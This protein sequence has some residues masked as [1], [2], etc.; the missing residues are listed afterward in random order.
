MRCIEEY[1][2]LEDDQLQS[3]GKARSES[4]STW[5]FPVKAPKGFKDSRAKG[6]NGGSEHNIQGASAQD[7]RSNQE[8][9]VLSMAEQDVRRPIPEA[10]KLVLYLP[11]G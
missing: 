3:K 1:K 4:S 5:W 6:T 10:P 7:R 2:C 11:Q 9:A 8:Q